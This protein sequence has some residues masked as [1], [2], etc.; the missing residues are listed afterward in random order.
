MGYGNYSYS[1]HQAL[2]NSRADLPVEEIFKQQACHP[3][4]NPKGVRVR[5]SRDSA[6]HPQS[7][8]IVFALDVSGSMGE[9]PHLLATRQL[10]LFMKVLMDCKIPDPQVLFMALSDAMCNKAPLQVGQ[11]ESTAVF[12][13]QWLTWF[14]LEGGGCRDTESYEL[15]MFILSHHTV[16]D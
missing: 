1:A 13:H 4:M 7:L 6:N 9:I 8:G 10:P 16:S 5:E 3:L 12:M 15:A 14:F 11:F 2:L